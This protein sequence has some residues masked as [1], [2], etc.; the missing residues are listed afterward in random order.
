MNSFDFFI[1]SLFS[2][3]NDS[4]FAYLI[5]SAFCKT[6]SNF[7]NRSESSCVRFLI[8]SEVGNSNAWKLN[9]FSVYSLKIK[10]SSM[11]SILGNSY[12]ELKD[13]E[14]IYRRSKC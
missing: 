3:S 4:P 5:L 2:S 9:R 12:N 1:L 14:R 7:D 13:F 10:E 8:I 11:Y 6:N